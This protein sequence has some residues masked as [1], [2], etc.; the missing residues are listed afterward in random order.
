[1]SGLTGHPCLPPESHSPPCPFSH[2]YS[3]PLLRPLS[4]ALT[5]VLDVG[6]VRNEVAVISV[7]S[8]GLD[9]EERERLTRWGGGPGG[10]ETLA[11]SPLSPLGF[12]ADQA[13]PTAP[14]EGHHG[15]VVLGCF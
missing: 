2:N 3:S 8:I 6:Q 15:P 7:L 12:L 10:G 5:W 13:E 4:A 9:L 11:L 14:E 1:V